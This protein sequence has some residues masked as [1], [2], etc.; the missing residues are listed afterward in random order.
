MTPKWFDTLFNILVFG[1][2][3]IFAVCFIAIV[4][5]A[6]LTED[7]SHTQAVW[8]GYTAFIGIM[9]FMLAGI[10]QSIGSIISREYYGWDK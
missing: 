2:L 3:A 10:C 7:R 6:C 4:P 8:L 5:I 9:S 1:F